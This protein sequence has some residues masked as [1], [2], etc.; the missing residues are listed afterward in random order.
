MIQKRPELFSAYVGT[1]QIVNMIEGER[2]SLQETIRRAT[3]AGRTDAV[4]ELTALG[5]P[6]YDDIQKF[7]TER[8]WAGTFDT[9]S[10]AAFDA[11]WKNPEWFTK[12]DSTERYRAWLF[13]NMRIYDPKLPDGIVSVD[14]MAS[15]TTLRVPVI[16][17]QGADDHITPTSLVGPYERRIRAPRKSLTLLPGGGHNAIFAMKDAFLKVLLKELGGLTC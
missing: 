4:S 7:V 16:F 14:F 1:G 12:A 17:I 8:K 3:V 6:P 9:P 15:A 2:A 5:N 13:S 10:D 11:S